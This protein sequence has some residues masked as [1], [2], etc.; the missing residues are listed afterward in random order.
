MKTP[1]DHDIF[2]YYT[3]PKRNVRVEHVKPMLVLKKNPGL[4]K[5]TVACP[6]CSSTHRIDQLIV[7][8][9]TQ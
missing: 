6:V 8:E 4:V 3:C 1:R 9:E 2:I 7:G 5:I